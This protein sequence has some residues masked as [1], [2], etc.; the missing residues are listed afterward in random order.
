LGELGTYQQEPSAFED[1][2]AFRRSATS[3]SRASSKS[4]QLI[5]EKIAKLSKEMLSFVQ[6]RKGFWEA[7]SKPSSS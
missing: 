4:Q 6:D 3:Q 5:N 1:Q 7:Q 2:S